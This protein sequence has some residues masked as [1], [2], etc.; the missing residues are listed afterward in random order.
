MTSVGIVT[1]SRRVVG[2]LTHKKADRS[3]FDGKAI[4]EPVYWPKFPSLGDVPTPPTDAV[5]GGI[6]DFTKFII[7][8]QTNENAPMTVRYVKVWQ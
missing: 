5:V 7:V 2:D 3:D 8:L 1:G 4:G 6:T